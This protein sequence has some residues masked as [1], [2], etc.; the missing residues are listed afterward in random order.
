LE[1]QRPDEVDEQY[2]WHTLQT[3]CLYY[4][5]TFELLLR[6]FMRDALVAQGTPSKII[7]I[8]LD[9]FQTRARLLHLFKQVH[10]I[11]F[12]N[13][14]EKLGYGDSIRP[15]QGLFQRRN[16]Y[17]HGDLEAFDDFAE[18]DLF[19]LVEALILLFIDLNNA[20]ATLSTPAS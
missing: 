19:Q 2:E 17:A 14:M 13:A 12:W 20:Y 6:H 1:S 10:E 7:E 9:S 18:E 4:A 3:A 5:T 11:P 15:L 16:R 8:L